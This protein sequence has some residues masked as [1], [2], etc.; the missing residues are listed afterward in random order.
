VTTGSWAACQSQ[1]QF[2]PAA[3]LALVFTPDTPACCV[4]HS[5]PVRTSH[6][7]SPY[8]PATLAQ[9]RMQDDPVSAGRPTDC[10]MTNTARTRR[11]AC[12]DQLIARVV[13]AKTCCTRAAP[14]TALG[15]KHCLQPQTTRCTRSPPAMQ[16]ASNAAPT[17][18]VPSVTG[19]MS[20]IT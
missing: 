14:C 12:A 13:T 11:L 6:W 2:S 19:G 1:K 10:V 20:A 9:H 15:L 16:D 7:A 18:P 17:K 8:L 5:G 3:D 4:S